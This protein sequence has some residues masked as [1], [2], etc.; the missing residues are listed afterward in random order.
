MKSLFF[1][2]PSKFPRILLI[3][4][5]GSGLCLAVLSFALRTGLGNAVVWS[6]VFYALVATF[7]LVA[8][9]VGFFLTQTTFDENIESAKYRMLNEEAKEWSR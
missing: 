6:C 2:R 7:F 3:G 1:R 4:I 8:Q 9:V 5:V